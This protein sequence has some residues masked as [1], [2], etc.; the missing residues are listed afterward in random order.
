MLVYCLAIHTKIKEKPMGKWK[1]RHDKWQTG[2]ESSITE[3]LKNQNQNF[4]LKIR[5]KH[6][7]K[8]EAWI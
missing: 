3:Q 6:R 2:P 8:F 4:H 1:T 5:E 7:N